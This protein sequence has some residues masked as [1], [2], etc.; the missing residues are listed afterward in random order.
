MHYRTGAD[1][2]HLIAQLKFGK[3]HPELKIEESKEL[4]PPANQQVS[5]AAIRR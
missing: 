5:G 2:S 3:Q 1:F 4:T